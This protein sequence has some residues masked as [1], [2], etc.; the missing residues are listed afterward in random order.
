METN[1]IG[2]SA[3]NGLASWF[4]CRRDRRFYG[5][6]IY[7]HY[8]GVREDGFAVCDDFGNLVRVPS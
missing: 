8:F 1:H 7:D 5:V 2:E 3:W 4:R 6:L